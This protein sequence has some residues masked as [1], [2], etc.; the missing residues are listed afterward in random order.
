MLNCPFYGRMTDFMVANVHGRIGKVDFTTVGQK[1]VSKLRLSIAINRYKKVGDD[2]HR[3]TI[4]MDCVAWGKLAIQLNNRSQKGNFLCG[5]GDIEVDQFTDRDGNSRKSYHIR[6]IKANVIE[7]N[8]NSSTKR[9]NNRT[10]Q[11]S[12]SNESEEESPF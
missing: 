5:Y 10:S 1:A 12:Y 6:L 3:N 7:S 11:G 8:S 9:E 4:W 2:F